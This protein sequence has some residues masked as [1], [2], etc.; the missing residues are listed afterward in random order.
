MTNV[1]PSKNKATGRSDIVRRALILNSKELSYRAVSG[2]GYTFLGIFLRTTMTIGS[3]A[4]LARLLTPADFGYI[5]MATVITELAGLFGNF[6][7]GAM[8][9]QRRVLPR[10]HLD[11]VFWAST[12]LGASLSFFVIALSYAAQWLFDEPLTADLLKVLSLTFIIGGITTVNDAILSRLMLFR[13][14]FWIQMSMMVT[15]ISVSIICALQGFGVWSLVAGSIAGSLTQMICTFYCAPFLPRLRFDLQYITRT[16]RTSGSYFGGGVLFYINSNIDLLLIGRQLGATSLGYYQNARSLTDEVRSRIAVPLQNVLFPAF[17]AIQHHQTHLQNSVIKSGRLVAAVIFPVAIGIS[18]V[19]RELVPLLYGDQWASMIPVLEW[20]GFS[21]ALRG[22]TAISRP[23]FNSQNRPGLSLRYNLFAT[24]LMVTAV[25][26]TLTYGIATVALAIAITS[27][28]S[29][30]IL[31]AALELLGL[32]SA[33]LWRILGAPALSA[34]LMWIA[35]YLIRS[36]QY[37]AELNEIYKFAVLVLSGALL[38]LMTL[39]M[40][41]PHYK[42]DLKNIAHLIKNRDKS[43]S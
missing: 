7:F 43:K 13:T 24:I 21:A 16:W 4:V 22:S 27:L 18:S 6:G 1:P 41:S 39:L 17:S 32:G 37:I 25:I 2:A 33:A 26:F 9:I 11:T 14:V 35:I 3:M 34:G 29:L 15:R 23:I 40:I 19:S 20:L 28:Y 31:R 10:L 42:N 12:L 8:L 30:V 36:T 38:Y 5:A